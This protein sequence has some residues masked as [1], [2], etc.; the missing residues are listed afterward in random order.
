MTLT[1][2]V[3]FLVLST[4]LDNF[5]NNFHKPDTTRSPATGG[6]NR[7]ASN[8][9]TVPSSLPSSYSL[10]QPPLF[11]H[12]AP[13]DAPAPAPGIVEDIHSRPGDLVNMFTRSGSFAFLIDFFDTECLFEIHDFHIAR[14]MSRDEVIEQFA[15]SMYLFLDL[16]DKYPHDSLTAHI[17]DVVTTLL[18]TYSRRERVRQIVSNTKRFQPGEWKGLWEISLRFARKETDNNAKRNHTHTKRNTSIQDRVVYVEH[19]GRVY[20]L[21]RSGQIECPEAQTKCVFEKRP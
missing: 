1:P 2:S 9:V 14:V 12:N 19:C 20:Y 7:K 15:A 5:A 21:R 6:R 13:S 4:Y 10:P 3:T 17:L 8:G 18:M 16:T 11:P